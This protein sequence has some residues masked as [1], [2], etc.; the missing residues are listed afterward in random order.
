[1]GEKGERS[2][3]FA[4]LGCNADR[5]RL[6]NL[7][8]ATVCLMLHKPRRR[9]SEEFS[10]NSGMK[11]WLCCHDTWPC[12]GREGDKVVQG[13]LLGFAFGSHVRTRTAARSGMAGH[14]DPDKYGPLTSSCKCWIPSPSGRA[15]RNVVSFYHDLL[16]F[17]QDLL[18]R[19]RG[20]FS[21]RSRFLTNM[22]QKVKLFCVLILTLPALQYHRRKEAETLQ[23]GE[24]FTARVCT[25]GDV[26]ACDSLLSPTLMHVR[27]YNHLST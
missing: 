9:R 6:L 19:D 25:K 13:R 10:V 5:C 8:C 15:E 1:M 3:R 7:S 22:V 24:M 23:E 26:T 4:Q 18:V 11:S 17:L 16:P 12:L 27:E 21:P 20:T 2:A 14:S